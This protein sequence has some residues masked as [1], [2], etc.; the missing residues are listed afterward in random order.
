M[1][2]LFFMLS[3]SGLPDTANPLSGGLP[4]TDSEIQR[5]ASQLNRL[6]HQLKLPSAF[7]SICHYPDCL[8]A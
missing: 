2:H 7:C 6:R 4:S 3:G 1:F 5:L 8:L